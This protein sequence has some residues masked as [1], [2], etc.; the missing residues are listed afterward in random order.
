M[1][2]FNEVML[3]NLRKNS[4]KQKSIKIVEGTQYEFLGKYYD[5]IEGE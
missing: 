4:P 3:D 5:L 1:G 2:I